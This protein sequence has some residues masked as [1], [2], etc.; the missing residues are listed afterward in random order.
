[1]TREPIVSLPIPTSREEIVALQRVRRKAAFENALRAPFHQR[2]LRGL[3]IDSDR[4][5]DPDEWNKIPLLHKDDLRALT[6]QEYRR[7]F[8]LAKSGEIAEYWRSGGVTGEPLFYPRTYLDLPYCR[9]GFARTFQ[10]IGFEVGDICHVS[11]PLGVHP[12]GQMWARTGEELGIGMIW[13]GAGA[14]T[15]SAMQLAL[16]ERLRPTILLT[17]SSYALHL[18]NLAAAQGID[19]ANSSIRKII[20][21]AEPLSQAKRD[22]LGSQWNAEVFDCFGMT[23]ATMMGAESGSS[24]G[25]HIWTDLFF[26]EVLDVE[27]HKPVPPGKPGLLVVTPLWSFNGT[28]FLRWCSGDVVVQTE[29]EV[30]GPFSVFPTIRHENRTNGFFKVRGI[31]LS[32]SEFEEFMFSSSDVADFKLE[33]VN[34]GGLDMLIIGVEVGRNASADEFAPRLARIM[35][36]RFEIS[37]RIV[38]HPAGTIAREFENSVKPPRFTDRR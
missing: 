24:S 3:A 23:E 31:N 38:I 18:G 37:A 25:Y 28:P 35:K 7:D 19:I 14:S 10:C 26:I 13:A 22:K 1:M 16:I 6:Q 30:E 15:P 8:C 34:D 29:V 27:T 21:T 11:M 32:H 2:R 5:A 12:A 36:D 9:L 33:V 17:M 20:C 4:V